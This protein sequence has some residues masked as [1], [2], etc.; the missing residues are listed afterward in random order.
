M[1]INLSSTL[2]VQ[3]NPSCRAY[4]LPEKLLHDLMQPM[5]AFGLV[6]EQL[7][8]M[9]GAGENQDALLEQI[10]RLRTV[11][12][13]EERLLMSLRSYFHETG[14]VLPKHEE[15]SAVSI[16]DLENSI[17]AHFS[18]NFPDVSLK[19][20]GFDALWAASNSDSLFDIFRI[21][22]D[23]AGAHATKEVKI[24]VHE[25]PGASN[26]ICID[27]IDD[28]PGIAPSV[29]GKL[30]MP[31]VRDPKTQIRKRQGLGLG[32]FLAGKLCDR[33]G[34]H[35]AYSAMS[36]RGCVFSL[37]IRKARRP[38][39]IDFQR[40][41]LTRSMRIV[42]ADHRK[43]TGQRL[44]DFL[45][46]IGHTV[47]VPTLNNGDEVREF[48]LKAKAEVIVASE[49]LWLELNHPGALPVE[50]LSGAVVLCENSE[51][52]CDADS[53]FARRLKVKLLKYPVSPSRL[54]AA[55]G[56]L[57]ALTHT[58]EGEQMFG[59][60]YPARSTT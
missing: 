54:R 37:K 5:N 6:L 26:L 24:C 15:V 20:S 38:K 11:A 4:D 39:S 19:T 45:A 53:P 16:L 33:L 29:L 56:A 35:L 43:A 12:T 48:L 9:I 51:D 28:G 10:R 2:E 58:P 57:S 42:V 7:E 40:S 17:R 21:L 23:N 55:L 14:H 52:R 49:K 59:A 27:V 3:T 1:D 41:D 30:G 44:T 31:F 13:N 32:L 50:G 36:D 46:S 25:V 8:E 18:A 47:E 60:S 34:H 22:G